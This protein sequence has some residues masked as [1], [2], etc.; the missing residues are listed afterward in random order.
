MTY[1]QLL[2]NIK[3]KVND[4][5]NKARKQLNYLNHIK[6]LYKC[7]QKKIVWSQSAV[8]YDGVLRIILGYFSLFASQNICCK[9]S[10]EPPQ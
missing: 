3:D 8:R 1:L 10:I 5:E 4:S 9:P 6:Y 2:T 7:A